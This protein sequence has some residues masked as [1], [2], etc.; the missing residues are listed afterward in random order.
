MTVGLNCV[1]MDG[2]LYCSMFG[3][4]WKLEL[5]LDKQESLSS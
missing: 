3:V 1:R 4:L 5:K 2:Y